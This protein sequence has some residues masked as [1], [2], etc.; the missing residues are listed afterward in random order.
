M[1]WD[2]ERQAR[3]DALRTAELAGTLDEA[4]KAE[5]ATLIES[6][7]A[8]ERER[9]VPALARM[10]AEQATLRQQVQESEA[11]NEQLVLLAA[12]QEQLLADARKWLRDLRSR[13]QA[14]QEA[15]Q[16]ITGNPLSVAM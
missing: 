5:L 4:A 3:L 11:A 8:E 15:Y 13:H 12:Q 14:I 10:Q 9:L 2:D 6:V 16:H 7:E 1:E